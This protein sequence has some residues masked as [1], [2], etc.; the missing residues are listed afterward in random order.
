MTLLGA[1]VQQQKH[2]G[3][4]DEV[5]VLSI[6]IGPR[7][8]TYTTLCRLCCTILHYKTSVFDSCWPL[9]AGMAS[10]KSDRAVNKFDFKCSD[11][12]LQQQHEQAQR[13]RVPNHSKT[14]GFIV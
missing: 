14:T 12:D 3:H 7:P 8:L 5:M 9:G 11:S 10:S 4:A 2:A 1:L 6:Q 13:R